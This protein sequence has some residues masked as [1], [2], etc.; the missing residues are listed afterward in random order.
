[1]ACATYAR[2]VLAPGTTLAGPAIV[3]QIDSTTIVLPGQHASVDGAG[4]L[5]IR[6]SRSGPAQTSGHVPRGRRRGAA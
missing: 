4:N 6:R 5:V 1:V 3:E 2:E